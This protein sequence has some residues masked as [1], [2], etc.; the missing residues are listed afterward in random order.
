[1][2]NGLLIVDKEKGMTSRDVVNEISKVLKTK[3]VGHTGTLDPLATGVLIVTIGKATKLGEII[4]SLEK[5]YQAEVVLGLKTDT[6]DITGNIL[7]NVDTNY[8][9]EEINQVLQSFIGTYNQE[10]PIYSAVKINGRKLY[11]YAR[12]NEKVDLPKR[13]VTIKKIN[14]DEI[15][16]ENNQTVFK[17]TCLV[18]KGTYIRSLIS[19]I[20]AKLKTVGTMKNLRRIKQGKYTIYDTCKLE[21]IK[22]NN[23]NIIS[24]NEALSDYYTVKVDSTLKFKIKNGQVIDDIYGHDFVLFIDDEAIGLYKK[25]G[26]LL[27]P[28]KMFI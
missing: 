27:K 2:T 13:L 20:A 7:K 12:N 15:R 17:F 19:D 8:S 5:S 9:K 4:T 21:D 6:L 24:I 10:V 1:M 25:E 16:Q 3:K 14:L 18:S 11:E 26:N 28:Y 23:F 22:N